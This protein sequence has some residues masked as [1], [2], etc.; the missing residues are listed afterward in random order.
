MAQY[1]GFSKLQGKLEAQGNSPKS[2]GAIAAF[3]GRKKYGTKKFNAAAA[4]GKSLK[5]EARGK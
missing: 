1:M 3:V 4:K 2:A 5:P